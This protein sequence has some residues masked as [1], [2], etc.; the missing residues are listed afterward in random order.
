[1]INI[2]RPILFTFLLSDPVKRLVIDLMTAYA[3]STE[4]N[5][6]DVVVEMVKKG[7]GK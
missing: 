7:L 6:D 1:M 2:L 3:K 4:T 5:I